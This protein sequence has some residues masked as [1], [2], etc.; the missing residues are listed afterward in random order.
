V[1]RKACVEGL[2][3]ERE[4]ERG[5]RGIECLNMSKLRGTKETEGCMR[6][7]DDIGTTKR[8]E[9]QLMHKIAVKY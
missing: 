9:Q 4:R 6:I 8:G 1:K 7:E 5:E 3:R 2:E